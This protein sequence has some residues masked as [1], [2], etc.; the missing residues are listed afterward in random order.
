MVLPIREARKTQSR[1]TSRR[2]PFTNDT[3]AHCASFLWEMSRRAK[4]KSLGQHVA[5]SSVL[6]GQWIRVKTWPADSFPNFISYTKN[7]LIME[8]VLSGYT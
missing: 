3:G 7:T 5:E 2:V 1:A 8:I 4:A 6:L